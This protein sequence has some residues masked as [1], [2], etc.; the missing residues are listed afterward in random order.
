MLP[1]VISIENNFASEGFKA[2]QIQDKGWMSSLVDKMQ[3]LHGGKGLIADDFDDVVRAI[4][5][6]KKSIADILQI[7]KNAESLEVSA[8]RQIEQAS[9]ESKQHFDVD[10]E[11]AF[12]APS[13]SGDKGMEDQISDL[14][15]DL[16]GGLI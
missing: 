4:A 15:K 2:R 10:N 12:K 14:E 13:E 9:Q 11:H 1:Y 5:P 8:R 6:Y 16:S 3:V 7:L